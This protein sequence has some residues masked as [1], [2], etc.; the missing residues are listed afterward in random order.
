MAKDNL[1]W[2]APGVVSIDGKDYGAE[3]PLPVDK[4][5]KDVLKR[6]VKSGKVGKLIAAAKAFCEEC[7]GLKNTIKA[8][9]ILVA[10]LE[11]EVERLKAVK[12]EKKSGKGEGK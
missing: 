8:R 4:L 3:M 9:D 7:A 1:Y 12:K 11:S 6:L 10:E 2:I 5:G